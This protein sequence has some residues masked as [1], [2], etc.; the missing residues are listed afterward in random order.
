MTH[1]FMVIATGELFSE[2]VLYVKETE[3]VCKTRRFANWQI[4]EGRNAWK[5]GCSEGF[6]SW[7]WLACNCAALAS[8]CWETCHM[9]A[10]PANHPAC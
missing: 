9:T 4:N 8:N 1:S 3:V 7:P 5:Y 10:Q 2:V 6:S